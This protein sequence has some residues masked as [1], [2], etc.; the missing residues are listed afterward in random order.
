MNEP[1][2]GQAWYLQHLRDHTQ[3]EIDSLTIAVKV[4]SRQMPVVSNTDKKGRVSNI[5]KINRGIK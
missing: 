5:V 1:L 2:C 3:A 4:G